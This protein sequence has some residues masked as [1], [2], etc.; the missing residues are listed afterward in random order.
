M[1]DELFLND[2]VRLDVNDGV[3]R[4]RAVPLAVGAR[5]VDELLKAIQHDAQL[6]AQLCQALHKSNHQ[7]QQHNENMFCE[8]RKRRKK[9]T[10]LFGA[11]ECDVGFLDFGTKRLVVGGQ[12]ERASVQVD[13]ALQLGN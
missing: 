2:Y 6:V 11:N 9:R 12:A 3:E 13:R 1:L 7:Q 10:H 5:R 4:V 8:K